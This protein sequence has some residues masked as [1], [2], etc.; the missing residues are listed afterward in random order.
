MVLLPG[1]TLGQDMTADIAADIAAGQT[2]QELLFDG[3]N[4]AATVLA[5]DALNAL[6][7]TPPP[8][9]GAPGFATARSILDDAAA[10]LSGTF[11][12]A[13]SSIV[14]NIIKQGW[15]QAGGYYFSLAQHACHLDYH[16]YFNLYAC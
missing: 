10:S 11:P 7:G 16:G 13:I 15:I 6:S 9:G 1:A 2:R 8:A 12:Q 5:T 4:Q 14:D 3:I